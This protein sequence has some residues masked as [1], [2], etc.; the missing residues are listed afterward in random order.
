[1]LSSRLAAGP[2][3]QADLALGAS[4]LRPRAGGFPLGHQATEP[5]A[6][7]WATLPLAAGPTSEQGRI[8]AW[9]L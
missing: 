8:G 3:S 6:E 9:S 5:P 7:L 1:M 2:T 4:S